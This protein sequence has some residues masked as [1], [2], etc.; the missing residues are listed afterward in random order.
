MANKDLLISI[1]VHGTEIEELDN[2]IRHMNL[3]SIQ[4]I[5]DLVIIDNKGDKKT[6]IFC[7]NNGISYI[8]ALKNVGFG[9]GH[10][11]ASKY[12]NFS[13][14]IQL[15]LNPDVLISAD[16]I[17]AAFNF[18]HCNKD[19]SLLSPKLLNE[20]GSIQYICRFLPSPISLTKRFISKA[21]NLKANP[22][23]D[24]LNLSNNH[25]EVPSIH[26]ACFF[27]RSS[28][29]ES[30]NGFDERYFLYVEDI[31]LC[32]ELSEYGSIIYLPSCFAIHGHQRGSYSNL[33]LFKHHL[34]SFINYFIKWGLFIDMKRNIANNS[35][36]KK[37]NSI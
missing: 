21:F 13:H 27:V 20:D 35:A 23:E 5:Y 31:D 29:L 9:A 30:V 7:L 14:E 4:I 18:I 8:N 1:V 34:K 25:I 10:N 15:I 28:D 16:N 22:L 26:G 12:F 3:K 32:R 17:N 19:V 37:C 2:V 24:K 33:N 11:L 6:E 36:I